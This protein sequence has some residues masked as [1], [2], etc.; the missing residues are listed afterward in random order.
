MSDDNHKIS[1]FTN[2]EIS[3]DGTTKFVRQQHRAPAQSG[4]MSS[5][6]PVTLNDK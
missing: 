2:G 4:Y 5:V 1:D 3:D 6:G